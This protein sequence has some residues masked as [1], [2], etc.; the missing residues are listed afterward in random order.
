MRFLKMDAGEFG[1]DNS[2]LNMTT[3]STIY[4]DA[5]INAVLSPA[6]HGCCVLEVVALHNGPR[7]RCDKVPRITV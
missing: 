7:D 3:T 1:D 4:D 6:G 2:L 5:H